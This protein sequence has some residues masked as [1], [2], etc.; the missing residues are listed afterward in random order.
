MPADQMELFI[1]PGL[2]LWPHGPI[3]P[4]GILRAEPSEVAVDGIARGHRRVGK[5]VPKP[6]G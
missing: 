4:Q 2:D 5:S 6:R 1:Q 3:T